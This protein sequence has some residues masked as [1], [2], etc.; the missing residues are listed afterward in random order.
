[1]PG[2][3]PHISHLARQHL[4]AIVEGAEDAIIAK[5]LEGIVTT[6]N[7]AAERIFGYTAQE[8]VG[9]SIMRIIPPGLSNEEVDIVE[10]IRRGERVEHFETTRLRKDGV[11][12]HVSLTIS[13]IRDD[14]K[15]IGASK[16]A[17]DISEKKIW[18]QQITDALEDTR[19]ARHQAELAS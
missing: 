17:R 14:G 12:I 15:V 8:M 2:R 9:Q 13:P 6:W 5:D 1:M 7:P 18:E 11:A 4:A 3:R 10:R 16:I 19:R